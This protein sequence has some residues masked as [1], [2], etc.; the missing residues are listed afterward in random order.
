MH[1]GTEVILDIHVVD[2]DRVKHVEVDHV[3]GVDVLRVDCH[4][5]TAV[6]PDVFVPEPDSVADLVGW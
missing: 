5:L 6:E 1:N 3:P 2:L 4:V